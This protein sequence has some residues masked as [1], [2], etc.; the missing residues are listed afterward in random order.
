VLV[1]TLPTSSSERDRR[2]HGIQHG[3]RSGLEEAT[4]AFFDAMQKPYTY[5]ETTLEFAQPALRRRYTP[6]F[7]LIK[8]D[9]D[10]MIIETKGRWIAEDRKKMK[11]IKQQYPALDIRIVFSNAHARIS[12]TSQTTYAQYAEQLGYPWAHRKVP[13]GWMY[14]CRGK[15][16]STT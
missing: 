13:P 6:D 2:A 12:K 9:G 15:E 3:Y 16:A 1:P 7:V 11:L 14:E 5:E 10:P 4:A 8:H